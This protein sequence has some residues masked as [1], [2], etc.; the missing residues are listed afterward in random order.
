MIRV[1]QIS[2]C[3]SGTF[4]YPFNETGRK[5]IAAWELGVL[6]EGI[7]LQAGKRRKRFELPGATPPPGGEPKPGPG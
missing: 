4:Q 2:G 3:T 7:D 5:E 1:V 6:L